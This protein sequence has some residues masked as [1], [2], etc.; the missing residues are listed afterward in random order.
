M[1]KLMLGDCLDRM[2]EIES[3]SVDLIVCDLPY[4][5][6]KGMGDSGLAKEKG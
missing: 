2:K 3:G 4:G 5:T 6:I 1:I